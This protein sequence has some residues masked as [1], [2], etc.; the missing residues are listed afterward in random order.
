[1][2]FILVVKHII[3]GSFKVKIHSKNSYNTSFKGKVPLITDPDMAKSLKHIIDCRA[4]HL[5]ERVTDR[6]KANP[7][8]LNY[9]TDGEFPTKPSVFVDFLES[10]RDMAKM[11]LAISANLAK[12]LHNKFPDVNLFDDFYSSK[13]VQNYFNDAAL[14]NDV[15]T[16]RGVYLNGKKFIDEIG[17]PSGGKCGCGEVKNHCENLSDKLD[18]ALNDSMDFAKS[19]YDTKYERFITRIVSGFTAAGF[20]GKDFFNRAKMNGKDDE[21]A[22]KDKKEKV[23]QEVIANIGEAISQF[24]FLATFP[25]LANTKK[26]VTPLVSAGIGFTF[27]IVSRLIVGRPLTRIKMGGL[28]LPKELRNAPIG[29]EEFK[30]KSIE[31]KKQ[32]NKTDIKENKKPLLSLKNILLASAG[33]IAAGFALR[34][35]KNKF[36]KTDMY[37][38]LQD[39]FSNSKIGKSLR[40]LKAS[41]IENIYTDNKEIVSL[42]DTLTEVGEDSVGKKIKQNIL[43]IIGE[44]EKTKLLIGKKYKTTKL[45]GRIEIPLYKIHKLPLAPLEFIKSVVAF[46][47]QKALQLAEGLKWVEKIDKPKDITD[48]YK[49]RNILT[50]YREFQNLYGNDREVFIENFKKYV[51]KTHENSLNTISSSK[52]ENEKITVAA[53][54]LGM[55]FGITFNM[56][57]DYNKTVENGGTKVEAEKAAR[58]RGLNKFTRTS[59]QAVVAATLNGTFAKQYNSSLLKAG[60]I[61]TTATILTDIACRIVTG[62]PFKQ[63]SKEEQIAYKQE[64]EKGISGK[65]FE[66]IDR[67]AG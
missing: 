15:A 8:G 16:L 19:Q 23:N 2:C 25:I 50:R 58:L 10:F 48:P 49:M 37:K 51:Q 6:I 64:Q 7:K 56:N 27:N 62:M 12:F 33:S 34:Y 21:T 59:I 22:N 3:F 31:T 44:D 54:V 60:I 30:K 29:I 4:G 57:D 52:I 46:P 45:F 20:L 13:H 66:F 39:M 65:Y 18:E 9:L 36:V 61:T 11:P 35:G 28:A 38:S 53:Q 32:E 55:L 26:W 43:E 40:N 67:L 14:K 5:V 1:M 47:Y 63:M 41:E 42:C 17:K 24:A